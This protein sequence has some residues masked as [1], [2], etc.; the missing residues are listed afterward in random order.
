M[1]TGSPCKSTWEAKIYKNNSIS[2]EEFRLWAQ[3]QYNQYLGKL[4]QLPDSKPTH[5]YLKNTEPRRV[6]IVYGS[7]ASSAEAEAALR[8][9]PEELRTKG[10]F[11]RKMK[12]LRNEL[13]QDENT[14][15]NKAPNKTTPNS[16]E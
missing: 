7:Y 5:L 10:P 11:I 9:L 2:K 16:T 15:E 12:V 4:Q 13:A 3:Y 14:P 8:A 6:G 1:G